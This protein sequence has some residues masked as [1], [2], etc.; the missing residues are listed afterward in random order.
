MNKWVAVAVFV[1]AVGG[2]APQETEATGA[3]TQAGAREL[4]T[5]GL[6]ALKKGELDAAK[7]AFENA[8]ELSPE[9]TNLHYYLGLTYHQQ[10]NYKSAVDQYVKYLDNANR[11]N[12]EEKVLIRDANFKVAAVLYRTKDTARA[13]PY[14]QQAVAD[15]PGDK[16]LQYR[17]GKSLHKQGQMDEAA[18]HLNK[19]IE[20]DP[21]LTEPYYLVGSIAFQKNQH[22]QA[23]QR[24]Q[25]FLELKPDSPNAANAYFMLGSVAV[26]LADEGGNPAE[27]YNEAKSQL[28][29]S[30]QL[31]PSSPN[32]PEAH[33]F[34]GYLYDRSDDVASAR[35][36]YK[37]YI[38]LEPRG[39]RIEVVK[40]RLEELTES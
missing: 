18:K 15:K 11:E 2:M 27:V 12:A 8:L 19:V 14:L 40:K 10:K 29:K 20:L 33:Y 36:H 9:S 31:A 23:T 1:L 26:Q 17:L 16:V 7:Q 30:L 3:K 25:K 32:A 39:T 24:L 21:S 5:Q 4:A 13:I 38:E 6:E 28:K 37:K 34:L 35:Q 22:A